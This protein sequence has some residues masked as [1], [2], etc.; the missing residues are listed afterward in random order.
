LKLSLSRC[1][2]HVRVCTDGDA[3]REDQLRVRCNSQNCVIE[4]L[5]MERELIQ[6]R[7]TQRPG[8]VGDKAVKLVVVRIAAS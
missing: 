2:R 4:V 7:G 1:L 8:M 6:F 3:A 5:E